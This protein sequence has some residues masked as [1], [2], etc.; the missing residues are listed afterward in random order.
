MRQT[1]CKRLMN[2]SWD[3]AFDVNLGYA[4]LRLGESNTIPP[5]RMN[6]VPGSN[7]DISFAA[8]RPC[9]APATQSNTLKKPPNW[10]VWPG[11]Q[12]FRRIHEAHIQRVPSLRSPRLCV[13]ARAT[14]LPDACSDDKVNSDVTT[15]EDQPAP[16][17]PGNGRAQ[18]ASVENEDQRPSP[19]IR[20]QRR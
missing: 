1:D 15:Q 17:P 7:V 13:Q 6:P 19:L 5:L 3:G 14:V 8:L 9:A 12:S 4:T 18:I 16:E 11:V 2:S 20:L 10:T